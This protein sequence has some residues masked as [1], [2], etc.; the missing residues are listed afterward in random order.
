M[1]LSIV[2]LFLLLCAF[3]ANAQI[4]SFIPTT[5]LRAWYPF[6]GNTND[7]SGFL[8]HATPYGG[9]TYGTDRFGTPAQSLRGNAA[10]ATDIVAHNFPKGDSARSAA[11]YFKFTPPYPGGFRSLLSWGSNTLGNRFGFFTTDTTIGIEF[12]G[13]GTY[14]TPWFPDTF[15]HSLVVTYPVTSGGTAAISLYMDGSYISS[16]TITSPVSS[17]NTDTGAWH[18]I[19]GS[20]GSSY[21]DSWRGYIDDVAVWDRELTYCEILQIAYNGLLYAAGT[22]TGPDSICAGGTATLTTIGGTAG[23]WS[24]TNT[25]LATIGSSTGIVSAIAPGADT[26]VY[27]TTSACGSDTATYPITIL[28]HADCLV[29]IGEQPAQPAILSVY[30]NPNNGIFTVNVSA[31]RTEEVTIT[32]TNTLGQ[33]VKEYTVATNTQKQLQLNTPAGIYFI[34]ANSKEGKMMK[35][36][37]VE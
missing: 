5:G 15:W 23:T 7:S 20:I 24:S 3:T 4:P 9:I 37:I 33:P 29:H 27:I 22:I 32:I 28:S 1:K 12:G 31:A 13:G 17:F 34:S 36:M 16:P 25:S 11:L 30:P 26:I 8:R 21:S 6:S 10:S 19:A 14:T 2:S 35:K 18:N